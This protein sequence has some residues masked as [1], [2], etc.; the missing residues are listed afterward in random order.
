M[1]EIYKVEKFQETIIR[2][3]PIRFNLSPSRIQFLF[4][5]LFIPRIKSKQKISPKKGLTKK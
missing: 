3:I 4:N 1:N 5:F 2:K